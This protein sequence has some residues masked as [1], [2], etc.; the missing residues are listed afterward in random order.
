[1]RACVS[2][3]RKS[4]SCCFF[5]S[6]KARSCLFFA[7]ANAFSRASISSLRVFRAVALVLLSLEL[8]RELGLGRREG[9]ARGRRDLRRVPRPLVLEAAF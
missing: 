9:V 5:A 4:A 7:S 6:F 2:R 8:P 1:M 3:R